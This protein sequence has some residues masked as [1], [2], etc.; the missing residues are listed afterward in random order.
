MNEI[1]NTHDIVIS[2]MSPSF[3]RKC[4]KS[5]YQLSEIKCKDK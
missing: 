2:A 5:G 3:C 4:N 1:K